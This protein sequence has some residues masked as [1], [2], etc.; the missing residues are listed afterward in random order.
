[1][2]NIN[3]Y[4]LRENLTA[5]NAGF[6]QWGFCEKNGHEYFI[7]EFLTP[8]YP[9]DNRELSEKLLE[10]KRRLCDDFYRTK[11]DFYDVL[12]SCRTGNTVV[13]VDFFRYGSKY[14]MVTDK[15]NSDGTDPK[16]IAKLPRK[17]KE[18]LIRSILFSV[19]KL[20]NAGIIH[21][22]I[23]PDNM[24]LKKTSAGDWTAKIVDFDSGFLI[25]KIPNEIQGDFVYLSPEAYLKMNEEEATITQKIDIFALGILFHQYWTGE[26]PQIGEDYRYIFEA[27]LDD[28]DVKLHESLPD[29]ITELI[30]KMLQ[31][32]PTA[33]PSA[34]E[35]LRVFQAKDNNVPSISKEESAETA[36]TSRLKKSRNFYIP[37]DIS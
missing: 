16:I 10:R 29:G 34:E 12:K 37:S 21:A 5:K 23:K 27:V 1:M 20:H 13:V 22:D 28:G 25:G 17:Q 14:Y 24:M 19:S 18:T 8:V 36:T 32:D 2:N 9:S 26:L 3:G 6:S 35:A 30:R 7:K 31:K 33:R 11:A 15:V 4:I